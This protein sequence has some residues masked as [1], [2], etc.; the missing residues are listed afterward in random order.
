MPVAHA[1]PT[2]F[3]LAPLAKKLMCWNKVSCEKGNT[4]LDNI[5]HVTN[6]HSPGHVVASL[7]LFYPTDALGA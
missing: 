5:N 4:L 1:N 2:K 3:V 7:I 6:S